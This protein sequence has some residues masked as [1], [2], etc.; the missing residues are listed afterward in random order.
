MEKIIFTT[1]N[2]L[3]EKIKESSRYENFLENR[4]V[5]KVER[6]KTTWD[7]VKSYRNNYT[8]ERL[9]EIFDTVDQAVA[10]S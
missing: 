9:N 6:E 8:K 3:V 10:S 1:E 5:P 2:E 4:L 7:L